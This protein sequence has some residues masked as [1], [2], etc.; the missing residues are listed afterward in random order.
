MSARRLA[1]RVRPNRPRPII[2][3]TIFGIR[4]WLQLREWDSAQ[5]R[6][7]PHLDAEG[8]QC[9]LRCLLADSYMP[10]HTT[11]DHHNRGEHAAHDKCEHAI[12][13]IV[14]DREATTLHA[15]FDVTQKTPAHDLDD[16]RVEQAEVQ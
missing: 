1:G 13:L 11:P 15:E 3:T 9:S 2:S 5:S 7:V 6:G 16:M 4:L 14:A 10:I 12:D 8:T